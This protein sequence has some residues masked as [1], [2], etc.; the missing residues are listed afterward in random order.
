M[1]RRDEIRSKLEAGAR[2]ALEE[3]VELVDPSPGP[4]GAAGQGGLIPS[5]LLFDLAD[6]VRERR[7]PDN[8][9]TYV[10]DRNINYSNVCTSICIFCAFYRK[11]GSAEGYVLAYEEIF[12]KVEETLAVGG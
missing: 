8:V 10:V 1:H 12:R 9:V 2:L 3:W 4:A 5:A 7:H 6:Q 11:P